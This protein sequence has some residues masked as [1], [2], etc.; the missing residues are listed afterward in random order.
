MPDEKST[1]KIIKRFLRFLRP[2]W[3][4]GLVAFFFMLFVVGLEIPIPFLTKYL[5]DKV[6]PTGSFRILNII[7]LILI[8]I[9]F[10]SSV[11]FFIERYLLATFRGRVLFDLRLKLFNHTE[12]LKIPFFKER[13]T[14][15]L[16]SR[17]SGDVDSV[18]GLLADTLVTFGQN[19]LT[20]IAGVG[21]ALY[22]H[23]KLAII[24]FCILPFY[25][26]SIWMFNKRIRK[27][28]WE[29]RE[30]FATMNK[31]L[32]ELLSGMTLLKAFTGERYGTLRLMKSLKEG[33]K[34]SVKRDILST[35]Y[36]IT[37]SIIFSAAPLVLLWYGVGEIMRGDLTIG[38]LMAFNS[39][40]RYLFGPT[41]SFMD[42][43]LS[44]Q[45]SL[46]SVERILEIMDIEEEPYEENGMKELMQ[47]KGRIEFYNV[48]FSYDT[49]PILKDISF[50][51]R[52]GEKI[53]I[54]GESG[55]GKS[56]IA[57][58]LLKF[59]K[60]TE[61]KI[62]IDGVDIRNIKLS[63]L[64]KNIAYVSQ[65]N[66]LFSDT[67]TE[68]IRFGKRNAS[69]DDIK[70]AAKIAGID[71]FIRKLPEGYETTIGERGTK[72]SGG[73][74]QRIAIARAVL[75]DAPI[76]I[77]D[78]ATSNLD[79]KVERAIVKRVAKISE[80]KTLLVIAHRLSTIIDADRILV[81]DNGRLIN[82]GIHEELLATSSVY[83][84]LYAREEV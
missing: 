76:I 41:R 43:N 3:I 51:V 5:I 57:S 21:A 42:L 19:I 48:S 49:Q 63:S 80:N 75:K 47:L 11:S 55:V 6:I 72:L 35:L 62:L 68:N 15:Y 36:S 67:I 27:M 45:Q 60:P 23:P 17:L 84:E 1:F 77:L 14:G 81:F 34:K 53:A 20:F 38:G 73:E 44:I 24:S 7:G 2:Y 39:F 22:I 54:V 46:A 33:I 16:M 61:G 10:L 59:Y 37:S 70:K 30:R 79:R 8:G 52:P 40:L 12:R 32:Q 13:E 82:A 26:F 78:E 9:L 74:R 65:D 29:V 31:D 64:R 66:F 58:L 18:Q 28:S 56:T 83:Q 71:N 69:F 50:E 25:A 4:K